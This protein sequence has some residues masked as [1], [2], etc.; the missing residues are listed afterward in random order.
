MPKIF[1]VG[2]GNQHFEDFVRLLKRLG[3]K[4]VIDVRRFPTSRWPE[5]V[6]GSLQSSLPA[7]GIDYV[8][9]EELGGYRGGYEK[10]T[11]TKEFKGGLEKLVRIAG[12][13]PS[14]I[15]CVEPHPGAC[16]RRFLAEKL[17]NLG[18]EVVHIDAK[19]EILD[20]PKKPVS[21]S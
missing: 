17:E 2:Y 1:T 3:V 15:M 13:S 4:R 10:Y 11:K 18:W 14:V 21:R 20:Y 16:H 9:L 6:K 12:E 8:H 7:R 5:F 19:G